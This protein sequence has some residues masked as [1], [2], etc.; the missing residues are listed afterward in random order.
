M[1]LDPEKTALALI[2]PGLKGNRCQGDHFAFTSAPPEPG[3]SMLAAVL[4]AEGEDTPVQPV[5]Q[6]K[7]E[8]QGARD[9]KKP[10]MLGARDK[11]EEE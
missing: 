1:S 11:S 2:R 3:P 10:E 4:A 6:K 5:S 9:E 8:M 7:T